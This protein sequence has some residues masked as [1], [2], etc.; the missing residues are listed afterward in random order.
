MEASKAGQE[1]VEEGAWSEDHAPAAV[2]AQRVI[3]GTSGYEQVPDTSLRD[4]ITVNT[5]VA[6]SAP[7][8]GLQSGI[9]LVEDR[10]AGVQPGEN[11]TLGQQPDMEPEVAPDPA[12]PP[13]E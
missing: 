10:A 4:G 1:P 12:A 11:S 7:P 8:A 13:V 2:A 6:T 3:T 5:P 9:P